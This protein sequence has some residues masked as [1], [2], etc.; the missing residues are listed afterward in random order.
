M[1]E[2]SRFFG[3]IIKIHWGDHGQPYFHAYHA[4]YGGYEAVFDIHSG[5]KIE[6]KFPKR[7]EQMVEKWRM[8][9]FIFMI[10]HSLIQPRGRLL[11]P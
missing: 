10:C 9:Q 6:G 2:V 5:K 8:G 3:I 7:A 4:L 1:P 11:N